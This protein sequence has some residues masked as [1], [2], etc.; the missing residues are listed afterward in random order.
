VIDLAEKDRAILVSERANELEGARE[1]GVAIGEALGEARGVAIGEARGV[2]IG[3]ERARARMVQAAWDSGLSAVRVARL[4][5][6][7]LDVVAGQARRS[8]AA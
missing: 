2:A 4:L 6:L 1:E 3:E 7:P 5:G 8:G